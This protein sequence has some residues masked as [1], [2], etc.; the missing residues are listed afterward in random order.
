MEYKNIF[1]KL[2]SCHIERS[3]IEC[4]SKSYET[5]INFIISAVSNYFSREFNLHI[6]SGQDISN[7]RG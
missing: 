6:C 5:K 1:L 4:D 2:D 7:G 3:E